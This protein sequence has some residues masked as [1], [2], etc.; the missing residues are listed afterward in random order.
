MSRILLIHWNKEEAKERAARLTKLKHKTDILFDSEK[1]DLKKTRESPPDLFLIDLSRLPSQGREIAGYLRRLKSTRNVPVLFVGG[2][3]Q[4]VASARKLIPDAQFTE[5]PDIKVAIPS[6]IRNAPA[7]PVV[8]GTMADYSGSPLPKKLGIREGHSV[9]L[10]NSP[11]RFERKL[12]PLPIGVQISE[13]PS[14][15]N[16]A[17]FFAE[18]EAELIRDFRRLSKALPEKTALWIAWPKQ[19]SG[20]RTDLKENIVRE[21]GLSAGWVDYKVCAIDET[22]SGLCFARRKQ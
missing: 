22:W 9:V 12:D 13:D 17:V 5:W 21:F 10:V 1:R 8:P 20:V 6:A 7:T 4:R 18:S 2:D 11:E 3:A 14:A 19:T 16:V 15:A